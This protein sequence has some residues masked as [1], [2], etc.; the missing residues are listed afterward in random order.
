MSRGEDLAQLGGWTRVAFDIFQLE[1][2]AWSRQKKGQKSQNQRQV[3]TRQAVV[4]P[5]GLPGRPPSASPDIGHSN[6]SAGPSIWKAVSLFHLHILRKA[7]CLVTRDVASSSAFP[8]LQLY[9]PVVLGAWLLRIFGE[10]YLYMVGLVLDDWL[11]HSK[12]VW[13][14]VNERESNVCKNLLF[15]N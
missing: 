12:K 1:T 6:I 3:R 9:L 5:R 13:N 11:F 8:D 10:A 7:V 15:E 14:A 4:P 2:G